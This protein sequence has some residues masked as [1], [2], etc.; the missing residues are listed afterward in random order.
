VQISYMT[1]EIGNNQLIFFILIPM[2]EQRC[3]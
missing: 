2:L 1:N 3:I